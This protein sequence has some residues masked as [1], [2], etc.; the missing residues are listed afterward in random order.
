MEA[1]EINNLVPVLATPLA[2]MSQGEKKNKQNEYVLPK[3]F[4][5]LNDIKT[6]ITSDVKNNTHERESTLT[7]N[8]EEPFW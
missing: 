2:N 3:L 6:Q 1:K 8:D 4:L 5:Q 7:C